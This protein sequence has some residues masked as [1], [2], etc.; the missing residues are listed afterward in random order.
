MSICQFVFLFPFTSLFFIVF[1]SIFFSLSLSLSWLLL[2]LTIPE[3]SLLVVEPL[4]IGLDFPSQTN[5]GRQW[6]AP[7]CVRPPLTRRGTRGWSRWV[8]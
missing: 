8:R 4:N 1:S 3:W 5:G 2:L 7:G 6:R